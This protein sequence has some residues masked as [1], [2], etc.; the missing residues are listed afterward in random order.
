MKK[1]HD[2]GRIWLAQQR[3]KKKNKV[4][5]GL[6]MGFGPGRWSSGPAG[7]LGGAGPCARSGPGADLGRRGRSL[8]V[9]SRGEVGPSWFSGKPAGSTGS[10][11]SRMGWRRTGP[12]NG[13]ETSSF[14]SGT[15][16]TQ[17]LGMAP[18][19]LDADDDKKGGGRRE[20]SRSARGWADPVKNDQ[21]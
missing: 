10:W 12:V 5:L 11:R 19:G 14:V 21:I 2:T 17:R 13:S 3:E 20:R 1:I 15:K 4:T 16:P 6:T 7:S 9:R 8:H 18:A